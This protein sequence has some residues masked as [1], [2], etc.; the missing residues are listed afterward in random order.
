MQNVASF[1]FLGKILEEEEMQAM[2]QSLDLLIRCGDHPNLI[3]LLGLCEDKETIFV[4]VEE[5]NLTLKQVLL[6]SRWVLGAI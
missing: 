1:L 6:D 2:T 3:Q 5:G 4:V